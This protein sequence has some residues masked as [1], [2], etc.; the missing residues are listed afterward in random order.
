MCSQLVLTGGTRDSPASF[1]IRRSL[2][3]RTFSSAWSPLPLE[4]NVFAVAV[5]LVLI[6][7]IEPIQFGP[8][9]L[10]LRRWSRDMERG[11]DDGPP[12]LR[13]EWRTKAFSVA[14]L[15]TALTLDQV[16][17]GPAVARFA[18]W[19]TGVARTGADR[20]LPANRVDVR[21]MQL[22][23]LRTLV[24]MSTLSGKVCG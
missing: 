3:A 2:A 22:S 15:Y 23:R 18:V 6:S 8:R 7:N 14:V 5:L 17:D 19:W 13:H 24:L 21:H 9:G 12:A 16:G 4:S 20:S 10:P 1:C 11:A